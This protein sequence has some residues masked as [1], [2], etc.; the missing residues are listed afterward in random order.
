MLLCLLLDLGRAI[1]KGTETEYYSVCCEVLVRAIL[2]QTD[3]K[4]YC[5]FVM[6]YGI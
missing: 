3:I 6:V 4:F 5:F 1:Y 2:R